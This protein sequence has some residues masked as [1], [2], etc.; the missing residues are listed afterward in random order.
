METFAAMLTGALLAAFL[1]YVRVF[2]RERA[3]PKDEHRAGRLLCRIAWPLSEGQIAMFIL[4]AVILLVVR[5][6]GAPS[7][8]LSFVAGFL[9]LC[10]VVIALTWS[11]R[12]DLC[13]RGLLLPE[14]DSD[15]FVPWNEVCHGQWFADRE[16]FVVRLR[17]GD[18]RFGL[19]PARLDTV[20]AVLLPRI[21][22]RDEAGGV[23]NPDR[24]PLEID[25][26]RDPEPPRYQFHLRTLLLFLVVASSAFGWLGIELRARRER[27]AALAKQE[28]A[29]VHYRRLTPGVMRS[30]DSAWGLD[31]SQCTTSPGDDDLVQLSDMPDLHF[32][33]LRNTQITDAGLGHLASMRQLKTILLA[34]TQVTDEGVRKLQEALPDAIIVH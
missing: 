31:F 3:R 34:D 2:V 19:K 22:L 16:E 8:I 33:N 24:Q 30:G 6:S 14:D 18:L 17:D 7:C 20:M 13:Q 11:C 32:L 5:G 4:A 21:E 29:L 9:S 12:L 26:P 27:Q 28:A 10:A 25:P 15:C 23:L 1:G